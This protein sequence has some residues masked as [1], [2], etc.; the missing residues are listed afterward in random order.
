MGDS[1]RHAANLWDQRG[2]PTTIGDS[3]RL[4]APLWDQRGS[5]RQPVTL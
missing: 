5:E 3:E 4:A 2:L 1:E